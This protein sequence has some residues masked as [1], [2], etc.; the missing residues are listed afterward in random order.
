MMCL[1]DLIHSVLLDNNI[2]GP[3]D[4]ERLGTQ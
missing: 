3:R 2:K 4:N 1:K